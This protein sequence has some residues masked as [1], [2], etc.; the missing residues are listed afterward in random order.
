MF[1]NDFADLPPMKH[2]MIPWFLG[3]SIWFTITGI[4]ALYYARCRKFALHERWVV[5]HIAA[6]LWIALQRIFGLMGSAFIAI[7]ASRFSQRALFA[8]AAKSAIVVSIL[9]GEYALHVL[10]RA[11][12]E[13]KPKVN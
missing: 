10:D 11:K 8:T 9:L 5:R 2:A 4:L 13:L 1:T 3:I 12:A 7:P 6:G